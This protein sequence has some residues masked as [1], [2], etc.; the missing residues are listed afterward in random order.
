MKFKSLFIFAN[1]LIISSLCSIQAKAAD[2]YDQ[3]FP[4]YL[5]A[6]SGTQEKPLKT[7][8][9]GSVGHSF[10][11]IRGAC[12]DENAKYPRLRTCTKDDKFQGVGL[13]VDQVFHNV[14]WV[15]IDGRELFFSG[16]LKNDL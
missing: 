4:T 9:G 14:N 6:C 15:A 7:P 12:R 16:S 1:L 2:V 10:I 11:Y 5:E 8:Q 13:S 3:L